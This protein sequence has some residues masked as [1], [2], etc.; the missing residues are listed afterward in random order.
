MNEM[1]EFDLELKKIVTSN[2][3]YIK[4]EAYAIDNSLSRLI[5]NNITA[6]LE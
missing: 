1:E 2:L 3:E 6:N 5:F 4:K